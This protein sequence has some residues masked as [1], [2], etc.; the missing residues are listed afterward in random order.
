MSPS[1]VGEVH[2][3]VPVLTAVTDVATPVPAG[4]EWYT[5]HEFDPAGPTESAAA[6]ASI[7]AAAAR[8]HALM[9]LSRRRARPGCASSKR[10]TLR[11]EGDNPPR[12]RGQE[13][14]V[15]DARRREVVGHRADRGLLAYPA[16][17]GIKAVQRAVL[18]DG[19]DQT[20]GDDR[21]AATR[22]GSPR[23]AQRDRGPRRADRRHAAEA[24]KVNGHARPRVPA[25]NDIAA[26]RPQQGL[27]VADAAEARAV[28]KVGD[29]GLPG[30]DDLAV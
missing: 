4:S 5:V 6:R 8:S 10:R 19:P 14:A 11:S 17:R 16:V 1:R 13:E 7:P 22:S 15:A 27:L 30:S 20:G 12:G 3:R 25:V 26:R 24:G 28:E 23:Q 18:A 29:A 21:G 2:A 9:A